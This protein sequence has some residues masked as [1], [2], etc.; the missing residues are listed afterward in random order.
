MR[1]RI[2]TRGS[3]LALT[4]TRDIA[5]RIAAAI[6]EADV[7]EVILKTS[8]DRD[9][10]TPLSAQGGVGVFTKELERALLAEEI[11]LAVHSL[12]DL[13]TVSPDGLALAAVPERVSPWDVFVSNDYADLVDLPSGSKVATGS[14]RRRAQILHR[15]PNLE[16]IGIRGNID[17]RLTKY[18]ELGA[19]GLILA[20]AG[21]ARTGR[22]AVIRARFGPTEMTPAPGQGALGLETRADHRELIDAL[23]VIEHPATRAAVTAEREF[24]REL[25]GGCHLPIGGFARLVEDHL[26]LTGMLATADGRSRVQL[27]VE[28]PGADPLALAHE[29][30]EKIR[31]A[32]GDE[33]LATYR[34]TEQGGAEG[35]T[36]S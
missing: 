3:E 14:L 22:D 6:P 34:H 30:V 24:L 19:A 20:E 35:G 31:R 23:Q 25:E 28:G 21:L 7:E 12:K 16:V 9:Q 18:R 27:T 33:I 13:P 1:I 10:V 11:D 15:F 4:Q 29:L 8:G 32:G 2:G 26:V 36:A 17:T 5:R